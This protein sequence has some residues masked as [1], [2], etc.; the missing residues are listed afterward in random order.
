MKH[1]YFRALLLLLLLSPG[2][3]FAQ[4]KRANFTGRVKH[5]GNGST[6]IYWPGTM[7]ST[8]FSGTSVAAELEDA[9]GRNVYR[10][11]IDGQPVRD[12]TPAYGRK[13]YVIAENLKP[14]KHTV[15]LHR[16]TDW[17]NG[18]TTF[19][20]FRYEDGTKTYRIKTPRRRI[21]FYGNSIT[22]GAGMRER[23]TSSKGPSTNNYLSYSARTAR[24]FG[25]E[26]HCNSS[27]G[28][29][30]MI[31]WGNDIM[32]EIY[33]RTNPAD[34]SSVWDFSKDKP[35]IVVV[36]LLQNDASLFLQ[37]KHPQY[38]RQ[39]G[40][41]AAPT[42]ETVIVTYMGFI[43]N[44]RRHYP[45]ARIICALGSMGAVS[46]GSPWPGY[47]REAVNRLQDPRIHA[48]TFDYIGGNGHPNAA[49]HAVMAERLIAFIN[50]ISD[51]KD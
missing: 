25:A 40:D 29:G 21:A 27:S 14:G 9:T 37:P 42:P 38:I 36:N 17:Y 35:E 50:K 32:P 44:L 45:N 2:A 18:I 7:I 10:I 5:F 30:L 46:N 33:D 41:K 11:I 12:F 19:H 13:T 15:S 6:G 3:T 43:K 8:R 26:Y 4:N 28:I 34:S 20:G 47:I 22:V 49:E 1:T 48:F 51:W 24:H 39:F 23:D 31:S 16:Q